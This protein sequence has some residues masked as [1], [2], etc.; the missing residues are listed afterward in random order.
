VYLKAARIEGDPIALAAWQ[1]AAGAFAVAIGVAAFEGWP[2]GWPRHPATW[3]A[4]VHHVLLGI[5]LPDLPWFGIVGRLPA[6]SA[7]LGTL[8][9]P[10]V[11]VPG[12]IAVLGER[13]TAADRVGFALILA[14][15]AAVLLRPAL[16]APNA[17]P[18]RPVSRVAP[19]RSPAHAAPDRLRVHAA[20]EPPPSDVA[21]PGAPPLIVPEMPHDR[22][23]S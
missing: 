1:L 12:A 5:A 21:P 17:A 7:A 18:G 4:M 8:L 15:A 3:A 9:V 11:A 10:V 23:P 13:P 6:S 14:A 22:R 16:L 20:P 19:E 2:Q